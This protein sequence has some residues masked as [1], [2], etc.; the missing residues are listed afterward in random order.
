[1]P[2][3]LHHC[4]VVNMIKNTEDG[5]YPEMIAAVDLGSNSFHLIVARVDEFGNFSMIDQ[6]KEMVRLRGG[7][8]ANNNMDEAVAQGALECLQRFGD[9]IRHLDPNAVRAAGTNTLRTMKTSRD[10]LKRAN[11]ALGH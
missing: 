11:K 6:M 9:R 5:A 3:L 2:L 8:D 4:K 7:L 10:F 1:L